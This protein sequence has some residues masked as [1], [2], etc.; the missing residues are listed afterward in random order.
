MHGSGKPGRDGR[1]IL[2]FNALLYVQERPYGRQDV[3]K[4]LPVSVGG[5]LVCVV[6]QVG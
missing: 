2:G 3:R 4:R 6:V 1:T 5:K